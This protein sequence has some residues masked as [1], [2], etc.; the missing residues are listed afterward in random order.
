MYAL[1]SST[2]KKVI[3]PKSLP[4]WKCYTTI[5]MLFFLRISK[6]L[7]IFISKEIHLFLLWK[8]CFFSLSD[9]LLLIWG[10]ISKKILWMRCT[11]RQTTRTCK[12]S[13]I[14]CGVFITP[15]VTNSQ[16]ILRKLVNLELNNTKILIK[17]CKIS[18]L[19]FLNL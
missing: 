10:T 2:L 15:P 4:S 11:H 16:L 9:Y 13:V 7:F 1:C 18:S 17:K 19:W 14:R 5:I 6:R 3:N 12:W 8:T